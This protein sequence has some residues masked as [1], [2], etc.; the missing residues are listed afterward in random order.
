MKFSITRPETTELAV[1]L[2]ARPLHPE[3][4]ETS[5]RYEHEGKAYSAN[6]QLTVFGHAVEFRSGD[7]FITEVLDCKQA[8]LPRIKRLC[9]FSTENSRNLKYTLENGLSIRLCFECEYLAPDVFRR[10]EQEYWK[11][12]QSA[13]LSHLVGGRD[14]RD[15]AG[16]SFVRI[17]PVEDTLG[18][19]TFHLFPDEYAIV[20]TQS[21][22]GTSKLK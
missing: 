22:F 20:K 13:T 3:L 11:D 4:F 18:V 10:V 5:E 17:D 16:L 7:R 12:A 9:L 8:I 6:I 19:H 14:D 15:S 21:L 2:F 1:S